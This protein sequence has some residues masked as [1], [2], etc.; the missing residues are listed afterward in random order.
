MVNKWLLKL[1]RNMCWMLTNVIVT[2]KTDTVKKLLRNLCIFIFS[3]AHEIGKCWHGKATEF[4]KDRVMFMSHIRA[5]AYHGLILT[6][7][8]DYL[9]D[10]SFFKT[11]PWHNEARLHILDIHRALFKIRIGPKFLVFPMLFASF[12]DRTESQTVSQRLFKWVS[13]Y[14]KFV[15]S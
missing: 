5:F 14:I 7:A 6:F 15:M 1:V 13:N 9:F 8:P 3:F 12:T 4:R 11:W 2:S 10:Y